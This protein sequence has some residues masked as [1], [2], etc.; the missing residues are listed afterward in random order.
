[1]AQ[2]SKRVIY[3]DGRMKQAQSETRYRRWTGVPTPVHTRHWIDKRLDSNEREIK[4][5][6]EW[7]AGQLFIT[8]IVAL[9]FTVTLPFRLIFWIIA[10][11]GRL[12][13]AV[14]GFSL[15]VVGIAL[16]AGPLFFIG[17]PLF[18]VGLILT[19][20]CLD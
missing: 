6:S 18:L 11:M 12:T 10:W 19:L 13:A 17:I 15:M 5:S 4:P 7:S 20:R 9:W 16:W 14:L 1:V 3:L 8:L 2:F